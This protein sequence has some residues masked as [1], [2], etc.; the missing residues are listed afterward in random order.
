MIESNLRKVLVWRCFHHGFEDPAEMEETNAT[1]FG[2]LLQADV[3]I[4]IGEQ[5]VL[6]FLDGGEVKLL[7]VCRYRLE[8]FGITK[9]LH[10]PVDQ[11][12]HEVVGLQ[13]RSMT[14][15]GKFQDGVVEMVEFRAALEEQRVNVV[16]AEE[17]WEFVAIVF[18]QGAIKVVFEI[19]DGTYVWLVVDVT[20]DMFGVWFC[21]EHAADVNFEVV[22]KDFEFKIA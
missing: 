3:L 20:R 5:V 4:K 15:Y 1:M 14:G 6:C 13:L 11:P 19:E 9:S 21:N 10:D 22:A 8:D 18:L 17:P 12:E 2:E 16:V 7:Q